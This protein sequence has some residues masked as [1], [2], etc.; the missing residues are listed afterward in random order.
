[1]GESGFTIMEMTVATIMFAIVLLSIM[2]LLDVARKAK[3]NSME[4]SD[5]L[6]EARIAVGQ[7]AKDALN[8]G[9]NYSDNGA[10]TPRTWLNANL[11]ITPV[12]A[13]PNPSFL[14]PVIAG[15]Q[16]G[17]IITGAT[18]TDEIMFVSADPTFNALAGLPLSGS[19]ITITNIG[20]TTV[21]PVLTV[22]ANEIGACS[23][24]DIYMLNNGASPTGAVGTDAIGLVTNVN[25]GANT[26]TMATGGASDPLGINGPASG[27]AGTAST[28]GGMVGSPPPAGA[29]RITMVAYLVTIDTSGN[30]TGT[31]IRRTYGGKDS[32]GNIIGN[33]D[34]PLAFGVTGMSISYVLANGVVTANPAQNSLQNIRQIAVSITVQSARKDPNTNQFYTNTLNT[35]ISTRNLGYEKQ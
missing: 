12:P 7:M 3:F 1:T 9:V 11:G 31:L 27:T 5:D 4:R 22:Q 26:I 2:G 25:T 32:S 23:V 14:T 34:T 8:A 16:V 18:K 13:S 6:Q 29:E 24:G 28:V 17:A 19:P 35:T 15:N 33:I 21:A 30:G 20:G 10:E